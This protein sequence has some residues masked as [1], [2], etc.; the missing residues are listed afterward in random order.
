[1]AE[2]KLFVYKLS[3]LIMDAV[4]FFIVI[5]INLSSYQAAPSLAALFEANRLIVILYLTITMLIFLLFRCYTDPIQDYTLSDALKIAG[6]IVSS[7]VIFAV[8]IGLIRQPLPFVFLLNLAI[9]SLVLCGV[10]RLIILSVYYVRNNLVHLTNADDAERVI[11]FGAGDAGKYLVSM[12]GQDKSKMMRPV[13]FIDD[14]PKL[15][16]K[17]IKGLVVA[18]PRML[19]KYAAKKYNAQTIIIAIPFVDNSTIREIFNLCREANCKVKRFGN[20][21]N[22]AFDGLAKSTINEVR[23]EDLLQ[24][25]VVRLDLESISTLI[26]NKVVL[27]TGGAGSIGSELCKQ[28]LSYGAKQLIILDINENGLFNIKMDLTRLFHESQFETCIGS[29]RDKEMM[30]EVFGK[31]K[32]NIVF[33]AAAYK[34]VPMLEDNMREAIINNIVGTQNVVDASIANNVDKFILISTDKAV[35]PKNIMGATKRVTEMIIQENNIPGQTTFAAVRFGNVLGSNG[36][37]IPIFQKQIRMGG[38]L[39][40]THKDVQ[41]YFMTIPEAVQLVLEAG[42]ITQGGEIFVLDMGEPV[43]IY[44]LATTMILLSGLEPEKDIK[45]EVTGLR[46]GEKLFEELSL[47][48]ERVKKTSNNKIY[49]LKSGNGMTHEDIKDSINKVF[50]YTRN[51]EYIKAYEQMKVLIPSFKNELLS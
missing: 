46:P 22:L 29:T 21:S 12:L 19:I 1:M 49:V 9:Y 16:G 6:A 25:E 43:K 17:K 44:D 45:I 39:T 15:E 30:D 14:D 26:K 41:R 23:V 50:E 7:H 27:V 42:S 28:I 51:K 40:V 48:E 24:R 8:V 10:Y 4:C 33:H 3:A 47:S 11:I 35:N 5:T 36:S 38:P 13:A 32:P 31:Y 34:H 20:M 18:G 37:V 2:K